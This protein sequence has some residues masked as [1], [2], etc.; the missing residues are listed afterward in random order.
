[1]QQGQYLPLSAISLLLLSVESFEDQQSFYLISKQMKL[2]MMEMD[3]KCM[4]CVRIFGSLQILK[5]Q[6]FKH[7]E[8]YGVIHKTLS[9]CHYQL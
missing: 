1:M 2:Y 7:T 5:M 8:K 6:Y 3:I 4:R 9:R